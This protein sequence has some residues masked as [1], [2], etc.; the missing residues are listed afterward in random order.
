MLNFL[1]LFKN[2]NI[3]ELVIGFPKKYNEDLIVILKILSKQVLDENYKIINEIPAM[4]DGEE[5]IFPYRIY[6]NEIEKV[7]EDT[8]NEIQKI[9]LSCIFTRHH[10]G[11]IRQKNL[12]K[13]FNS[14]EN[15]TIPYKLKLLSEYVVE[16]NKDIAANIE[17]NIDIYKKFTN[18]NIK[19]YKRIYSQIDSQW[20]EHFKGKEAKTIKDYFVRIAIKKIRPSTAKK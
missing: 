1:N 15:F 3:S 16:I 11:Y 7:D 4:V 6:L 18:K 2:K 20:G 19:F 10:D 5:I 8:L 9:I 13:I 14:N 12:R 17:N